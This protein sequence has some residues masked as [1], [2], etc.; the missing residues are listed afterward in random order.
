M[1]FRSGELRETRKLLPSLVQGARTRRE[2]I[3]PT[4]NAL[5][6]SWVA[7]PRIKLAAHL[8]EVCDALR[9]NAPLSSAGNRVDPIRHPPPDLKEV[10]GQF[11]AKRALEIAA[12]GSHGMLMPWTI[13][14]RVRDP[15][16]PSLFARELT[17]S[18]RR[19]PWGR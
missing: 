5:E 12:A 8:L 17:L 1:L 15:L 6:A 10:R 11:I 9:G 16:A 19:S 3:L 14:S 7:A 4:A 18:V 2:L 13:R